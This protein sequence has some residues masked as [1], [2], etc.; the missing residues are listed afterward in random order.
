MSV[1]QNLIPSF[2]RV[3]PRPSVAKNFLTS[4][5]AA[6]PFPHQFPRGTFAGI[7]MLGIQP[8]VERGQVGFKLLASGS[9]PC[10]VRCEK[11]FR[12]PTGRMTEHASNLGTGKLAA[13]VALDSQAFERGPRQI[14]PR[15]AQNGR[16]R[17]GKLKSD[18]H[19][20]IL[21]SSGDRG[22]GRTKKKPAEIQ[23]YRR[24]R[25][26]GRPRGTPTVAS[27]PRPTARARQRLAWRAA[28]LRAPSG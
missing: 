16:R 22:N 8:A 28:A 13:P 1:G 27:P 5:A 4:S 21:S 17:L 23:D 12:L 25:L 19:K 20:S 3:N 9:G 2:I 18:G 7:A 11:L 14:L 6:N 15:I 24:S 26:T 10:V